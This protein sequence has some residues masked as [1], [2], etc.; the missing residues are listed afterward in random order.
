MD[1]RDKPGQNPRM[2]NRTLCRLIGLTCKT[3]KKNEDLHDGRRHLRNPRA[4]ALVRNSTYLVPMTRKCHA[5]QAQ[6]HVSSADCEQRQK[7]AGPRTAAVTAAN[8]SRRVR[9]N[10][11]ASWHRG[12]G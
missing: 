3:V 7:R 5:N 12:S 8:P 9:P 11:P 4:L 6:P 10:I 1:A 2:T